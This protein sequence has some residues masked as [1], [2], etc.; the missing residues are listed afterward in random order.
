M[1]SGCSVVVGRLLSSVVVTLRGSLNAAS[2]PDVAAVLHDLINGHG[3]LALVLDLRG[4][5]ELDHCGVEV[6]S[7]AASDIERRGGGLRLSRA[8]DEIQNALVAV[9]VTPLV[10]RPGERHG[11]EQHPAPVRRAPGHRTDAHPADRGWHRGAQ[12]DTDDLL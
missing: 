10:A 6:L 8:V 1:L 2:S 9:G 7:A 5:R 4:L 12:G 3:N 11:D